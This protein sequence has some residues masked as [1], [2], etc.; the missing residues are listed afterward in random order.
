MDF[1]YYPFLAVNISH[2]VHENAGAFIVHFNPCIEGVNV[3]ELMKRASRE[4][5][6]HVHVDE[7]FSRVNVEDRFVPISYVPR[8]STNPTS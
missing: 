6:V 3:R 8:G 4:R 2:I 1:W 5:S 7:Y